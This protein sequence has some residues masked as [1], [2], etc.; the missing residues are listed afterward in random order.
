[1]HIKTLHGNDYYFA[2]A[3]TQ[4]LI[5]TRLRLRRRKMLRLRLRRKER[6]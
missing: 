6:K 3:I 2:A 1:M 4:I 5:L